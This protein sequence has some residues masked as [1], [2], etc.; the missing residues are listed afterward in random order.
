MPPPS[1]V[2]VVVVL[3]LALVAAGTGTY[4]VVTPVAAQGK[5]HSKEQ[6]TA[7]SKEQAAAVAAYEKALREFK[8]VLVERRG[9]IEAK[10]KLPEK[11][12]QALYL[13]RLQVMST[14]KDLTDAVPS[15][16]GRPNKFRVPPAYFDAD[17]EP[18]IE[19][20]SALF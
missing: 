18:L 9:Q 2:S 20:Y 7:L 19:E 6:A 10:Q 13:A 15:W 17:I 11:P 5:A 4:H 1:P 3:A 14:Y 16:I 8:A 12:G